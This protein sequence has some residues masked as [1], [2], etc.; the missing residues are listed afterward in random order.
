MMKV[1]FFRAFYS[2]VVSADFLELKRET[3]EMHNTIGRYL[4]VK[5]RRK[6]HCSFMVYRDLRLTILSRRRSLIGAIFPN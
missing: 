4:N 1:S 2:Y 5:E 6:F 3:I